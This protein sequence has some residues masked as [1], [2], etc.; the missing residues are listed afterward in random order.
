MVVRSRRCGASFVPARLLA[1]IL[2]SGL[3]LTSAWLL[4]WP[5]A[6]AAM[7]S[8]GDVTTLGVKGSQ[9]Q[10]LSSRRSEGLRRSRLAEA[11]FCVC[12]RLSLVKY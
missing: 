12:C 5:R 9:V 3:L 11:L 4:G 1:S 8:T 7:T 2:S 6:L 10:I